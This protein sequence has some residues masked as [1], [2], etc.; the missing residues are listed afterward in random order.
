[1]GGL[2]LIHPH[3]YPVEYF[4]LLHG[5]SP[6]PPSGPGSAPEGLMPRREALW[7]GGQG[8]GEAIHPP[9]RAGG[10]SGIFL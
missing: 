7:A 4:L 3:L 10:Y 2:F 9:S 5:A 6:L 1:M 8:R